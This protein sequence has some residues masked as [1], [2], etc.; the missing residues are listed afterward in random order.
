MSLIHND[1]QLAHEIVR[2]FATYLKSGTDKTAYKYD[3]TMHPLYKLNM[4]EVNQLMWNQDLKKNLSKQDASTTLTADTATG[5]KVVTV[6]STTDFTAGD[7]VRFNATAVADGTKAFPIAWDNTI[8]S[9]NAAAK[10]MR[11]EGP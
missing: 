4:S 5:S 10:T 3:I 1:N 6:T 7:Y 11:G 9:I 2:A 8:A